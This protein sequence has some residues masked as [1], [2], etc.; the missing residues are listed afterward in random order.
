[1]L[2]DSPPQQVP[3][4]AAADLNAA[5]R[6]DLRA[7]NRLAATHQQIIYTLSYRV[8]GDEHEAVQAAQ[9]AMVKAARNI[10][11]FR[12]GLFHLWLLRWAVWACQEQLRN[13]GPARA[14]PSH[15]SLESSLYSLPTDLRLAIILVDVTGLDYEQAAAVLRTSREQVGRCVAD[16][17]RRLMANPP[18][19]A[20]LLDEERQDHQNDDEAGG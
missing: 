6:G 13:V 7:F 14:A 1:M 4:I 19:A 10:A 20:L 3:Q 16:A 8:L 15:A 18:P 11:H 5:R 2:P 12:R 9:A 17:R